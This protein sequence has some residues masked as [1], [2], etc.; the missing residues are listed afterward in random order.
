MASWY[1]WPPGI[2]KW[3]DLLK[4]YESDR[5]NF[6]HALRNVTDSHLNPD[7]Q[8]ARKVSFAAQVMCSTAAALIDTHMTAGKEYGTAK[9]NH[10]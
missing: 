10:S 9:Y 7:A 5:K 8:T 6:F 2:A 3:E 4:I 1:C